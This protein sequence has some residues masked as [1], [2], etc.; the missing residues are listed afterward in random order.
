MYLWIAPRVSWIDT[1]ARLESIRQHG[2]TVEVVG[3][4]V[5]R[6]HEGC[7]QNIDLRIKEDITACQDVLLPQKGINKFDQR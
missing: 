6:R 1:V 2:E 3:Q 7:S 4:A 5:H